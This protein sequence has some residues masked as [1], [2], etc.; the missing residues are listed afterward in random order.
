[1]E[2]CCTYIETDKFE[3]VIKFYEQILQVE[4]N[5]YTKDGWVEFY[6]GNKLAI[7]NMKYDINQIKDKNNKNVK[8]N[9]V[10]IENFNK[11]RNSMNKLT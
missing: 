9:Q 6:I 7:Y 5:I 4:S 11:Y 8:Y 2:L 1:M 3:E 10:Y